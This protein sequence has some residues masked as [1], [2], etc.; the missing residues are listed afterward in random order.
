MRLADRFARFPGFPELDTP[1]L[2]L[3]EITSD[4][5]GWYLAHFSR[6]EIVRGQGFPPPADLEAATRELRTY[7]LDLFALRAGFRWGIAPGAGQ[8]LIGSLGFY[9]WL[10]EPCPQAEIGYDL[11]P[12]WWGRGL[13]TEALQAI[14]DFGFRRMELARVEAYV[15]TDNARSIRLLERLDFGRE[16]YLPRHGEDEHGCLRDELRYVRVREAPTEP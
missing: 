10:D 8:Q 16:A 5:A 6:P 7:V 14:L 9:R 1:R 4:D 11:A 15:L 12:E 2:R 13:M 3:R